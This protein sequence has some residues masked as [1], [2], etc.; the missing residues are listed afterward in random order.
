MDL[1]Y[2]AQDNYGNTVYELYTIYIENGVYYIKET[3]YSGWKA[4]LSKSSYK[5]SKEKSV[6]DASVGIRDDAGNTEL[7]KG[8]TQKEKQNS[9]YEKLSHNDVNIGRCKVAHVNDNGKKIYFAI[10]E[11][12]FLW[13]RFWIGEDKNSDSTII[14]GEISC[15][16]HM[17]G[18]DWKNFYN[19][20]PQSISSKWYPS[21]IDGVDK[22]GYGLCEDSIAAFNKVGEEYLH[23]LLTTTE[24]V[25]NS[26][27]Y[28]LAD[29][30]IVNWNN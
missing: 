8:N 21:N 28:S 26:Y 13:I 11:E 10:R 2:K 16:K 22:N 18:L 29:F 3:N 27:G 12:N 1:S 24:S 30:G 20:S 15:L 19:V 25:F 23:E 6:V 9:L 5:D 17:G 4:V 14:K 7:P